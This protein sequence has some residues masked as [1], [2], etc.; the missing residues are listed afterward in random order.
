MVIGQ[1]QQ[2][3]FVALEKKVLED[4]HDGQIG[5]DNRSVEEGDSFRREISGAS[6]KSVL[7]V[8]SPE[9]DAQVYSVAPGGQI[10]IPIT[11]DHYFE[12][13]CNPD[14]AWVI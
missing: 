11:T 3:H 14:K 5:L 9:F 1:L 8:E 6:L 10:P 2:H 12:E 4:D 7:T 13:L